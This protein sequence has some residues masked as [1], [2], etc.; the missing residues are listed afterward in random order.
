[1]ELW[2]RDRVWAQIESFARAQPGG[3]VAMDGDGTL[4]SGDVGDDVFHAFLKRGRVEAPALEGMRREARE[5]GLSD[6]G[7][8][9]DVARRIYD[10]YLDGRFPEERMCELMTWCFAGWTRSEVRAFASDV[11]SGAGIT[12][13]L[14][15]EVLDLLDRVRA[16][17]IDTIVV[18][19]SPIDAIIEAAVHVGLNEQSIV[20]ACPRF[21]GDVMLADV[22]RPIPFAEGKVVRL[23]EHI[24]PARTVY[25]AFGDNAFD[26]ALLAAARLGVAVRPKPRLRQ[27]AHE[28]PGLVELQR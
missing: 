1:M 4:W 13:R 15:G 9:S 23:V 26:V 12:S 7:T 10:A 25:A 17:R 21:E 14:Q 24:G 2:S 8:G 22:E 3:V 27:R 6:A 28:L 16:A 20:A 5:H 11:V 19:A 18:S